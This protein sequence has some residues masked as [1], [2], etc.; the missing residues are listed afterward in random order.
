MYLISCHLKHFPG[1]HDMIIT[2]RLT[3]ANLWKCTVQCCRQVKVN[4]S[5]LTS[6]PETSRRRTHRPP[7]ILNVDI[8]AA[9]DNESH[10][11][12]VIHNSSILKYF[13]ILETDPRLILKLNPFDG[14]KFATDVSYFC[15]N[16]ILP[17]FPS[18][19]KI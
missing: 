9:I 3:T 18:R 10:C 17:V 1:S 5:R 14:P 4:F 12:H 2:L 6:L 11:Y 7:C 19:I 16:K 15:R 13:L 8:I